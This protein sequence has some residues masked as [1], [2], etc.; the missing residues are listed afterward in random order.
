MKQL[1]IASPDGK[2]YLVTN[3]L[4]KVPAGATPVPIHNLPTLGQYNVLTKGGGVV[5]IDLVAVP[6][7]SNNGNKVI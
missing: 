2:N 5:K 7:A 1:Y 6:V 3:D 4:A